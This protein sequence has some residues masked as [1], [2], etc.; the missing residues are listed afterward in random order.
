MTCSA[1]ERGGPGGGPRSRPH[2]CTATQG[3]ADTGDPAGS[4]ASSLVPGSSASAPSASGRAISTLT[5]FPSASSV[6]TSAQASPRPPSSCSSSVVPSSLSRASTIS[7]GAS[8]AVDSSSRNVI[9]I[10]Y[11]SPS[12]LSRTGGLPPAATGPPGDPPLAPVDA[13][14]GEGAPSVGATTGEAP[15]EGTPSPS[16]GPGATSVGAGGGPATA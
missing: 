10:T 7:A 1:E 4:T 15:A 3:I 8:S 6:E 5:Q 16:P 14:T 11:S 2:R 13:V 12:Q 9:V